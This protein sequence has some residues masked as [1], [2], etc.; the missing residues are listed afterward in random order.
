MKIGILSLGLIAGLFMIGCD[1]GEDKNEEKILCENFAK[2]QNCYSKAVGSKPVA[3]NYIEVCEKQ[4]ATVCT[5]EQRTI[6]TNF[7]ECFL[8][9]GICDAANKSDVDKANVVCAKELQAMSAA[10][11]C[12]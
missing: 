7:N 10:A 2:A 3:E 5:S 1:E 9:N 12:L 8:N 11:S 6:I 4:I